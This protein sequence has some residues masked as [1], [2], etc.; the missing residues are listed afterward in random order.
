MIFDFEEH[1]WW[2]Y[3]ADDL[4]ELLIQS[5]TLYENTSHWDRV[6]HDYSFVVF[7]AAKAYEGFLK[8]LFLDMN[9]ISESEYLG[10]HFRIGKA[11]N[12]ALE[13]RYRTTESVYD[14]LTNYCNGRDLP[15]QLWLTWKESRNVLFHWFP[16]EK[17][18][19]N[20][21]EAGQRLQMIIDSIDAVFKECKIK[22]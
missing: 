20:R 22:K 17:N 14:K 15:E 5:Q 12:P 16:K 9:F 3:L 7:P 6:F 11:L 1:A 13:K 4:K 8:K 21:K 19:I 18:A 10:K 2:N